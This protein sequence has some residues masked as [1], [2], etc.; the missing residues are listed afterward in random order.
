M[1]VENLDQIIMVVKKWLDDPW[2][3]CTPTTAFKDS[4][5]IECLLVENN[6]DLMEE[7]DF[8]KQ[9]EVDDN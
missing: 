4:M 9:L 5:K 1:Q 3:N 2:L 6:Y 8:F 7:V